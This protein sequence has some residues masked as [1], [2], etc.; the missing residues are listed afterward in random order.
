MFSNNIA[1]ISVLHE[2]LV[3]VSGEKL[4]E[5]GKKKQYHLAGIE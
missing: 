5:K 4:I 3:F 1:S 2:I